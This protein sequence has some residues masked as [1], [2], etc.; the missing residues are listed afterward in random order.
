M[1]TIA[2]TEWHKLS[3]NGKTHVCKMSVIDGKYYLVTK[4]PARIFLIS[5]K[6]DIIDEISILQAKEI[7][8]I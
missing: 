4:Y 3:I 7:G 2:F 6:M 5:E 8:I 1:R